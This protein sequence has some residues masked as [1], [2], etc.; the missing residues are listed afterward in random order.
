M[1]TYYLCDDNNTI[2]RMKLSI[3]QEEK[4]YYL[5]LLDNYLTELI[6]IEENV[7]KRIIEKELI[8]RE[9]K[10]SIYSNN[11]QLLLEKAEVLNAEKIEDYLPY[12]ITIKTKKYSF[13]RPYTIFMLI[14]LL[15][16]DITNSNNHLA[17]E[18]TS[19]LDLRKDYYI[20][21]NS[22]YE[23]FFDKNGEFLKEKIFDY[24]SLY[25]LFGSLDINIELKYSAN[26]LR[27]FWAGDDAERAT[28]DGILYDATSN[29][30][31]LKKIN[32]DF[33]PFDEQ[34][35]KLKR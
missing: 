24:N 7:S 12:I 14:N 11:G 16:D 33:F 8:D 22:I 15:S 25:S 35:K 10:D 29:K 19:L 21:F 3:K 4:E 20:D 5:S 17:K 34:Q 23:L 27:C 31:I 28:A 2:Y 1:F 6:F 13:L 9:N 32:S 26:E 18:I 30:E